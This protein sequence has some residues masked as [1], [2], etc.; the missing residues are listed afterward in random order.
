MYGRRVLE[1]VDGEE[2]SD[3]VPFIPILR[4]ENDVEIDKR[5]VSSN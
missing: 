3:Y 1:K 2:I 4:L 5:S